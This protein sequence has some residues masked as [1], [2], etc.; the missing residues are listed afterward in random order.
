MKIEKKEAN[1]FGHGALH[2]AVIHN[3][4]QELLRC[5]KAG[6]NISEQ[7]EL[8][9]TPLHLAVLLKR[10][11]IL[12]Q[13]LNWVE[14]RKK[15]NAAYK[16]KRVEECL[17]EKESFINVN[18]VSTKG[19][20]A[21][22]LAS[23]TNSSSTLL[24]L[25]KMGCDKN[26]VDR[27]GQTA[28]DVAKKNKNVDCIRL[29][30]LEDEL[31]DFELENLI[32]A[33]IENNRTTFSIREIS[34]NEFN[35]KV[36]N[37]KE[38]DHSLRE[39]QANRPRNSSSPYIKEKKEN[40]ENISAKHSE[41]TIKSLC[42]QCYLKSTVVDLSKTGK[43][44][45]AKLS[46]GAKGSS[47]IPENESFDIVDNHKKTSL[48]STSTSKGDFI[49]QWDSSYSSVAYDR[50]NL[51]FIYSSGRYIYRSQSDSDISKLTN[52]A[53]HLSCH[54]NKAI[55]LSTTDL[56]TYNNNNNIH[57][58]GAQYFVR[59]YY[60]DSLSFP[61]HKCYDWSVC[62][63]VQPP[64]KDHL[65]VSMKARSSREDVPMAYTYICSKEEDLEGSFI[66]SDCG[67]AVAQVAIHE[68][69]NLEESNDEFL[70]VSYSE[71]ESNASVDECDF[72]NVS[73]KD[74]EI[75]STEKD[76][77][78]PSGILP[79]NVESKTSK[80]PDQDTFDFNSDFVSNDTGI[81]MEFDADGYVAE[82]PEEFYEYNENLYGNKKAETLV[83]VREGKSKNNNAKWT[84]DI[85]GNICQTNKET[86]EC[87]DDDKEIYS[88][89]LPEELSQFEKHPMNT[90]LFGT[91]RAQEETCVNIFFFNFEIMSPDNEGSN[92][93][94]HAALEIEI[95]R[96]ELGKE[97]CKTNSQLTIRCCL[98]TS[99]DE[100]PKRLKRF[101]FLRDPRIF[102][103]LI[104]SIAGSQQ[105]IEEYKPCV[106]R[107]LLEKVIGKKLCSINLIIHWLLVYFGLLKSEFQCKEE[108]TKFDQSSAIVLLAKLVK[109]PGITLPHVRQLACFFADQN[110]SL[111]SFRISRIEL[112]KSCFKR[113]LKS[114]PFSCR[115]PMKIFTQV[116]L[117]FKNI[118]NDLQIA[119][120]VLDE[121]FA[122]F[123]H[124]NNCSDFVSDIL[125]KMG[126]LKSEFSVDLIG[127]LP[128]CLLLLNHVISQRYFPRCGLSLIYAFMKTSSIALASYN[129]ERRILVDTLVSLI[130]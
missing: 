14:E 49:N 27:Y 112:L 40:D 62:A 94:K 21:L 109:H 68:S 48:T 32:V 113:E 103:F 33:E 12:L 122:E 124:E 75:Y 2:K 127:D 41:I 93:V 104:L 98:G 53:I 18:T 77:I 101:W 65:N 87:I 57:G 8:G 56:D 47:V 22:H 69:E 121:Y 35:R 123:L 29:F 85:N 19:Q 76:H 9:F 13:L 66:C 58:G 80:T 79:E 37:S 51:P 30:G 61:S 15:D 100:N 23:Q 126:L 7:D 6:Y 105:I 111:N 24:I 118:D 96:K 16:C 95:G 116:L 50:P 82:D 92:S 44:V 73:L 74:S 46:M 28:M 59:D 39:Y 117:L 54:G 114:D 25:L 89:R 10:N 81:G 17:K 84:L 11:S 108:M 110:D 45:H 43:K 106:A 78:A 88:S 31:L 1:E 115:Y 38:N 119:F 107:F 60:D 5:L 97:W 26:I 91:R 42:Q 70:V 4:N 120:E 64:D 83:Q 128:T 36:S 102:A 130:S 129:N 72:D 125:I 63:E 55:C 71:E 20:T 99:D 90:I 34:R 67:S 52:N 86:G 3:R